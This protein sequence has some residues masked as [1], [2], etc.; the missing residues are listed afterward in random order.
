MKK[1]IPVIAIFLSV[2]G[3]AQTKQQRT[4]ESFSG[5]SAASGILVEITQ[6][7]EETL[8]VSSSDD[9]KVDNIKTEVKDGMLKIYYENPEKS[10][11][12][13]W[14]LKLKAYVNYKKLNELKASSGATITATNTINESYLKVDV[15]S[16][17]QLYATLK[18]NKFFV[19]VSSGAVLKIEG[20]TINA[21]VDASSGAVCTGKNFIT[22]TANIEVSSG[23]VVKLGVTKTLNAKASSGGVIGYNGNPEITKKTSSGGTLNKY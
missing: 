3:T 22:E 2:Q 5:I 10:Y 16:G 11:A 19:D 13:K 21:E 17:A 7:N 18:L 1:I 14:N 4:V 23:A 15:S 12:K 20:S 6:S 8:F 9:S